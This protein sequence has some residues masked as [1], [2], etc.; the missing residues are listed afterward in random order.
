MRQ[1]DSAAPT[2]PIQQTNNKPKLS[3]NALE[4]L[5]RAQLSSAGKYDNPSYQ[6]HTRKSI[7]QTLLA[8]T[9]L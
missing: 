8:S 3:S 6:E 4:V 2:P 7:E 1:Y 5:K 9:H